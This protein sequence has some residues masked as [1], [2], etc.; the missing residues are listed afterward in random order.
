MN[1]ASLQ[2]SRINPDFALRFDGE[3]AFITARGDWSLNTITQVD[4]QVSDALAGHSYNA[5]QYDL[6]GV[7]NLDTAGAYILARAARCDAESC[8][9]W[10]IKTPNKGQQTL[11]QVAADA[12]MGR[13]P[14]DIKPW[15]EVMVRMGMATEKFVKETYDTLA[16]LGQFMVI[17]GKLIVQPQRIK[18]K[19]VVA[20]IE[21]VGL[22]A[23]PIIMLLSFFIGAVLAYMGA[24]LLASFGAQIFMVELVGFSVLREFAVLITAILLAGRSDSAFTAQIGAMKMRQ[25]IDAMS[26]IGLD[27]F[28][29][30]VAPRA[31]ACLVSAPILT[32]FAMISGIFGGMLVAWL[33]PTDVTPIL[34]FARL[35]DAVDMNHFW[36]G[37]V[38]APFFGLIIAII[39]CRQ[40]LAVSG[41][42]NSLGQRTT[43]SV[44]QAIFAVI[45]LDA[46]FAML[47]LQL[48]V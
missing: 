2:H 24:N 18:W 28:E 6:D 7:T 17:M 26:V 40:G 3:C 25:E 39:G 10:M 42:V 38:K 33:G 46:M 13:P 32:F 20:L 37:M 15:Y 16:F 31:I 48:D 21:E 22:N 23:A 45:T 30:L 5:V 29:T 9:S 41:S 36:V 8:F 11:L 44:V 34:F 47:F 35:K 4:A 14:P 12:R 27:T 1:D 43:S 19:S